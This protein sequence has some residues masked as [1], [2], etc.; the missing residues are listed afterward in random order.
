MGR[1]EVHKRALAIRHVAFEDLGHF[2]LALEGA[3]YTVSY[4]D[5][6]L[7]G[8]DTGEADAADLLIVLGG[9]IGA[10]EDDRYPFLNVE[11]EILKARL[12]AERPTM[13]ICLGA[14]LMARA[15]GG[16]VYP[17]A[18]KEIGFGALELTAAGR[19][20]CLA[21]FENQPV[22][23]WHGDTFDLPEGAVLLAST[24]VCKN[25]AF[26]FGPSAVAFQFHPEAGAAGF[27]QWLIGHACELAGAGK[28]VNELRAAYAKHAPEV[29]PR[30]EAC[31][32]EWL[33]APAQ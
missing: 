30:A 7:H 9:P 8:V 15:L 6:G 5:V 4:R 17:G 26:A 21:H 29:R 23:H 13:G 12:A 32:R 19:Q 2:G 18:E 16:R 27:E 11:V 25:Q 24:R 10:Y 22:L 31:L 33:R 20:S 14:Q 3:G 28:D 1:V